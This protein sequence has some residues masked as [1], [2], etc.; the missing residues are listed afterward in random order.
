M[1]I[2]RILERRYSKK[3]RSK[4]P[5]ED[6]IDKWTNASGLLEKVHKKIHTKN[7]IQEARGQFIVSMVTALE[8]FLRD[9]LISLIDKYKLDYTKLA[10][11]KAESCDLEKIEFIIKNNITIGELI[12]E[13]CKFQNLK[14]IEECFSLLFGFSLF[15]ELK[16][17]KWVYDKKNPKG[18]IQI[19]SD[20]YPKL[21]NLLKLR[22]SITHDLNFKRI[23]N[24]RNLDEMEDELVTFVNLLCFLFDDLVNKKLK[25]SKSLKFK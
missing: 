23:I 12:V 10:K 1:N 18:F 25:I 8:V 20:F 9:S 14:E 17:Y 3:T 11:K 2:K 6:F 22:H 4:F 16:E 5:I 7:L 13:Y 19:S 21:D 24:K 15:K